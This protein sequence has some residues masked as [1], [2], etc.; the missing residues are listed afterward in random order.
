[1]SDNE[2][3]AS[4]EPHYQWTVAPSGYWCVEFFGHNVYRLVG[5]GMAQ[6]QAGGKMCALATI[7]RLREQRADALN[8]KT[9][10]GTVVA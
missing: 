7:K 5:S 6:T 3:V 9:L 8:G 4:P 10:R 2:S 1:M